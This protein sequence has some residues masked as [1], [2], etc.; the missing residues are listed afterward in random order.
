MADF[1]GKCLNEVT[2]AQSICT[3]MIFDTESVKL[4]H[5]TPTDSVSLLLPPVWHPIACEYENSL[6]NMKTTYFQGNWTMMMGFWA[7]HCMLLTSYH[8]R[9]VSIVG[10]FAIWLDKNHL[11]IRDG[12][13][14]SST[15]WGFVI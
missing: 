6:Y 15:V 12:I 4:G 2:S 14:I 5:L 3:G 1:D 13:I 9:K 8:I 7:V 10:N 11:I